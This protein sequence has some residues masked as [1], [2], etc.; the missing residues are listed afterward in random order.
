MAGLVSAMTPPRTAV[1]RLDRAS[2]DFSNPQ[3]T[4][5]GCPARGRAWQ[6]PA[7]AM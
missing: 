6:G 4:R 1:L 3:R 2:S 7:T 5:H